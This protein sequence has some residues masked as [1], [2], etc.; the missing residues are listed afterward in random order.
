MNPQFG[1]PAFWSV[2]AKLVRTFS[3]LVFISIAIV[4]LTPTEVGL[5][6]FF[7]A[8]AGLAFL[9]DFGFGNTFVR[10]IAQSMAGAEKLVSKGLPILKE[11]YE[12]NSK[13]LGELYVAA[14]FWYFAVALLMLATLA[15]FGT[16]FLRSQVAD[17]Q[18]INEII[19]IWLLYGFAVALSF[20]A[21]FWKN[22][23]FGTGS[24]IEAHK[25]VIV[26]HIGSALC[27]IGLLLS[28]YGLWSFVFSRLLLAMLGMASAKYYLVKTNIPLGQKS[29][30]NFEILATLWPM[31]WRQG[32]IAI[33]EFS[34]FRLSV[35]I[36]SVLFGLE[37]TASYGLSIQ[38]LNVISVV[39]FAPLGSNLPKLNTLRIQKKTHE[40]KLFFIN[41]FYKSFLAAIFLSATFIFIGPKLLSLIGS[42]TSLL[43]TTALLLLSTSAMAGFHLNGWIA[44]V[45]TQNK[46]PVA[47]HYLLS[48]ILTVAL[49]LVVGATYGLIGMLIANFLTPLFTIHIYAVMLGLNSF[50]KLSRGIEISNP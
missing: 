22:Y 37:V 44:I 49:S 3:A 40:L 6:Y 10:F 16:Y 13:L 9:L 34:L 35:V 15:T 46:N 41:V 2:L 48:S 11:Q 14:K 45:L 31:T 38:I 47:I 4:K 36:C 21:E 42:N 43:D 17:G 28:D 29:K 50:N 20:F 1:N 23:L 18:Y 19:D 27:T 8:V 32:L 24:V 5:Y 12:P 7:I 33:S 30:L 26:S 25:S 39:C